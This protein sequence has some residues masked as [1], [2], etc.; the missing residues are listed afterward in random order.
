MVLVRVSLAKD[1]WA[2][3]VAFTMLFKTAIVHFRKKKKIL[4][5]GY[6]KFFV[7]VATTFYR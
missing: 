3:L 6:L 2:R 7:I 5:V 4:S 1:Q